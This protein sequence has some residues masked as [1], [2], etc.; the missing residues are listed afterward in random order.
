MRGSRQP[1]HFLRTSQLRVSGPGTA[2]ANPG[3]VRPSGRAEN[4]TGAVTS[5]WLAQPDRRSALQRLSSLKSM[6]AWPSRFN[7]STGS[8]VDQFLAHLPDF[9][10]YYVEIYLDAVSAIRNREMAQLLDRTPG[11]KDKIAR[12][13]DGPFPGMRPTVRYSAWY[14]SLLVSPSA[15]LEPLFFNGSDPL[16]MGAFGHLAAHELW[17]AALGEMPLGVA[18]QSD[19]TLGDEH[20]KRHQCVAELYAKAGAS[21]RDAAKSS[22]ES[23]ADVVGLEVAYALYREGNGSSQPAGGGDVGNVTDVTGFTAQHLFFIASC[24]KW[25]AA[26]PDSLSKTSLGYTTPRLRCN[27]P[28]AVLNRARVFAETFSCKNESKMVQMAAGPNCTAIEEMPMQP[29]RD[30][31]ITG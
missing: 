29:P 15:A 17:H 20:L 21:K 1:A 16:S 26:T 19:L 18:P 5:S 8:A 2:R 12:E 23:V 14:G 28:V 3:S 6:V 7:D 27:V 22:P 11:S 24:L 25:C 4:R 10:G 13:E 30:Y 31:N 9:R